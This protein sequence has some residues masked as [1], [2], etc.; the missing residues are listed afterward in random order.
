M[1]NEVMVSVYLYLL[2][3]LTDYNPLREDIGFA[4]MV[5]VVIAVAV[6]LIKAIWLDLK[7]VAT[8]MKGKLCMKKGE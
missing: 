2:M 6:N 7:W 5:V 8:I 4:L 3:S 1:F